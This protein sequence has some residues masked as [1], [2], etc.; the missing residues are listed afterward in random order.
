MERL[1]VELLLEGFA[2]Y[3][4]SLDRQFF[5]SLREGEAISIDLIKA[6]SIAWLIAAEAVVLVPGW[7][8][9]EGT[10]KELEIA[11]ALEL[12]V[13]ESKEELV[14]FFRGEKR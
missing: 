8:K 13:F 5:L 2:P 1:S 12:P 14:A 9:S 3:C 7:E 10:K 4:P 6:Y 11:K